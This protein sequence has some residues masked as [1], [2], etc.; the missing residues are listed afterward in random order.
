MKRAFN[1]G[2]A[3]ALAVVCLQSKVAPPVLEELKAAVRVRGLRQWVSHELISKE[4]FNV[5][6]T[7][8][9]HFE[10]WGDR[11]VNG[12]DNK[13]V[14]WPEIDLG[15]HHICLSNLIAIKFR[16]LILFGRCIVHRDI[17]VTEQRFSHS[18]ID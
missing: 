5:G 8:G 3:E 12:T 17:A 6:F 10:H 7:S 9:C 18:W 4:I 13:L 1:I 14:A 2:K 15:C 16:R 11:L